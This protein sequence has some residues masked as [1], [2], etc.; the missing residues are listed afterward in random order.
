M[1][2]IPPYSVTAVMQNSAEIEEKLLT[3]DEV[4]ERYGKKPKTLGNW[5]S[6]G[7]GPVFVKAGGTVLY[8]LADLVA[9]EKSGGQISRPQTFC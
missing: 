4:C 6:A 7:K 8:R 9:W 2:P 5:R 3:V 1:F